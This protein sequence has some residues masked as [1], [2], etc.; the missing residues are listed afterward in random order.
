MSTLFEK[1]GIQGLGHDFLTL[2]LQCLSQ[3]EKETSE[4]QNYCSELMLCVVH[5]LILFTI[6]LSSVGILV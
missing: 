5:L 1:V 6:L 3:L 2:S 4:E